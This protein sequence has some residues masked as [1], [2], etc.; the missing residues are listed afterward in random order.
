MEVKVVSTIP[1]GE[2][3]LT[4]GNCGSDQMQYDPEL[5]SDAEVRCAN[6]NSYQGTVGGFFE[7]AKI[8]AKE[9]MPDIAKAVGKAL[10][11]T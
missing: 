10:G 2:I 6:C 9:K 11:L 5:G 1:L 3:Q 8:T 4:C 7:L